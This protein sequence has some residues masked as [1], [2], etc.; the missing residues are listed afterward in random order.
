MSQHTPD[1]GPATRDAVIDGRQLMNTERIEDMYALLSFYQRNMQR[2]LQM[3]PRAPWLTSAR[4]AQS[5][6]ETM[7][8]HLDTFGGGK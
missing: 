4:A 1:S 7:R 6:A 8:Q 2:L 3:A 5:P